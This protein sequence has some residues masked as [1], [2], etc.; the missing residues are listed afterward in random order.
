MPPI[1]LF[2]LALSVLI[3]VHELGHFLAAKKWRVF[4]DEFG[5]GYPPRLI[6]KKI[7]E[8]T[9]S[10]NWLP[11]GGFVRLL[12]NE[13]DC[14]PKDR[15]KYKNRILAEKPIIAR[16]VVM[17]SGI[18]MNL[19]LAILIFAVVYGIV[20]IP[21]ETRWVA[22]VGLA[23]NAPAQGAGIKI[24]DYLLAVVTGGNRVPLTSADELTGKIKE[25]SG[26]PSTLL[27]ARDTSIPQEPGWKLVTC[28][29]TPRANLNCYEVTLTPRENPP[30]GEGPLGVA[31]SNT[32]L[33][34][35]AI[36]QR[37]FWGVW[38]GFKEAYF[39]GKTI[40]IGL[41]GMLGDLV[42]KGKVPTEVAGPIGIY[43]ATSTIQ[44]QSGMLAV[45]HFFG[46]LS[47]N[48]AVVNLLPFPALDGSR[49]VLLVW[50]ALTKK[51]VPLKVERAVLNFGMAL[52]IGLLILITIGDVKRLISK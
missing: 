19:L 44:S 43:Q 17:L 39:W 9:Y 51:K 24:D 35:P 46:I 47:V 27:V 36:W 26:K 21:R 48:L 49:V 45:V 28:E 20:G 23:D 18:V 8:T 30:N 13:A 38:V 15:K 4:V 11:I 52:L 31:I 5:L 40:V 41:G 1:L 42:L 16:L 37:P 34:K 22:V 14:A 12:E 33:Y 50:E 2:I 6:S 3:M 7:G 10:L 25:L 29:S 32:E